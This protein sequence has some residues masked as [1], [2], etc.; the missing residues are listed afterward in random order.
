MKYKNLIIIGT[1]HIAKQSVKDIE[2]AFEKHKPTIVGVELDK[3]RLYGLLHDAKPSRSITNIRHFGVKG[4]LFALIGG[5]IQDK[6]GEI[7]GVKPGSDMLMAVQLAQ[8]N[9]AKIALLDQDIQITLKK[10]SKRFSWKERWCLFVDIMCAPFSRE[11]IKI[12]LSKVPSSELIK[13]LMEKMKY[14]YPNIYYTL[15]QERN[16]IMACKLAAIMKNHPEER[17]LAVIGAGHELDILGLIKEKEK[18]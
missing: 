18:N 10:F 8:K 11:K 9:Q 6:L 15:V 7:V 13:T 12:D 2:E 1:S 5:F 3:A 4:Y 17:I 14:R 16:E